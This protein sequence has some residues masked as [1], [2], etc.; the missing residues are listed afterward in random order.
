MTRREFY[1]YL[2][3]ASCEFFPLNENTTSFSI[4]I[5]NP[6]TGR[7]A[8]MDMPI[9]ERKMRDAKIAQICTQLGVEIPAC[10]HFVKPLIDEIANTDFSAYPPKLKG[11]INPTHN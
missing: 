11:K 7:E 5:R 4:G 8:F 9:D 1:I 2:Q 6:A 3:G 10:S